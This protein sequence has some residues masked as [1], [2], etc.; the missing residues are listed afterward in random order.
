[1]KGPGTW[2]AENLPVQ[3]KLNTFDVVRGKFMWDARIEPGVVDAFAKVWETD[4]LLVSFDSLN[5]RFPNREAK[6]PRVPW[7]HIDQ[8]LFKRGMYCIQGIINLSPAGA[9]DGSLMCLPRFNTFSDKVFDTQTG[10]KD[11]ELTDSV[12]LIYRN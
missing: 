11:S 2:K 10:A 8:S 12:M 4:E 3:S 9:Q 1:M 5:I 6:P 7:L